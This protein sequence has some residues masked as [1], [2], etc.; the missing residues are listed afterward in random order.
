MIYGLDTSVVSCGIAGLLFIT[1]LELGVNGSEVRM[2]AKN[3][4]RFCIG[5]RLA[6]VTY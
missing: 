4:A 3:L 2:G 5:S 6:A 1:A